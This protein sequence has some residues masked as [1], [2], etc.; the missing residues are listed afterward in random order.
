MSV[1]DTSAIQSGINLLPMLCL[2][3]PGAIVV[4]L[5]TSRINHFRWAI[6]CGW[7][8]TTAGAGLFILLDIDT[9]TPVWAGIFVVFGVG[10]GIS[11][12]SVNIGIQAIS[13]S[14]D[15]GRAA[16]MYTFVRSLGMSVG[17]AVSAPLL[18]PVE[19]LHNDFSLSFEK[20]C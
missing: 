8:I 15:C 19:I 9:K 11:L 7:L 10:N 5:I 13:K 3:I 4:A 20:L 2:I 17:V 12:T 16:S 18:L 6:W 14:E 1:K